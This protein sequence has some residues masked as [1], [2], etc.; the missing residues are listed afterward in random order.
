VDAHNRSSALPYLETPMGL[1]KGEGRRPLKVTSP[2]E[3]EGSTSRYK[4]N[5]VCEGAVE[6]RVMASLEG[7]PIRRPRAVPA[8]IIRQ[9]RPLLQEVDVE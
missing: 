9:D 3:R 7:K 5:S 4:P 1:S 2:F 8:E 6:A